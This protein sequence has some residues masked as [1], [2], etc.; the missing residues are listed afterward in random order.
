MTARRIALMFPAAILLAAC[1]ARGEI[2]D[3]IAIIAGNAIIK[4]SD[5]DTDIRITAFLNNRRPQFTPAARQASASRLLDQI[6]IR[7]E[8]EAGDYASAPVSEAQN[9]LASIRK[10]RY[11]TSAEFKAALASYEISEDDLKAHLEWQMTVLHF[12]DQRFRPGVLIAADDIQ[13]YFE[14][15]KAQLAASNP[16]KPVTVEALHDQIQQTLVG[17]AVNQLLFDWLNRRRAQARITYLEA[18]LKPEEPSK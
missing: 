16:G 15:H 17:E 5:I 2:V 8:I 4:D 13:K 12:I 1:A 6:F 14:E 9:L 7:K 11:P 3:R 10:S 18:S